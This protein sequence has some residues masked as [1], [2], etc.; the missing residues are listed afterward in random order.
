VAAAQ[1][2]EAERDRDLE[3]GARLRLDAQ[4]KTLVARERDRP[5]V[6]L[7]RELFQRLQPH[8]DPAR[9]VFLDES[10]F[11]LGSPPHYGW[12][13]LGQK[14]PGKSV[15]GAW[16]TIT[17]LGAIA[18]DGWRSMI[19]IDAATDQNV[20]LAFV[21]QALI[22]N[23]RHGDI[24]VMDNLAAHKHA[25]VLS[26][27]RAVGVDVLFLPPYSPEYNPIEKAWAKLKELVRRATTLTREAFDQAVA[28]AMQEI[29]CADI[30]AWTR[31]AG[32]ALAST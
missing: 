7:R 1:R 26:A 17:M 13:P 32:Y 5:Q 30:H 11:R 3:R 18:L 21:E 31:Y 8:L 22:P 20:F 10:G 14:S 4:K 12:A 29:S 15:E 23:L 16:R 25:A 2:P 28:A 19:T 27:L 24:V 9:L 6:R